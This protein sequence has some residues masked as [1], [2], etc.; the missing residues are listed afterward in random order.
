MDM[1]SDLLHSVRENFPAE[2]I[3]RAQWVLWQYELRP[4]EAKPT[5]VPYN[6]KTLQHAS[7]TDRATWGTFAE[8]CTAF[9]EN[10]F[11]GIGFVFSEDDPYFGVDLDGC[12]ANDEIDQTKLGY[13]LLLNSY[14]EESPSGTGIHIIAR[15]VMPDGKGRKSTEHKVEMYDRGRFF[16]VTGKHMDGAPTTVRE[17]QAQLDKLYKKIFGKPQTGKKQRKVAPIPQAAASDSSGSSDVEGEDNELWERMFAGQDGDKIRRLF[18]GDISD[19]G[20]DDSSADMGLCNFLA[21]RIGDDRERIERMLRQS[22]LVRDK[23]EREDY[24]DRTIDEALSSPPAGR[25]TIIKK[26]LAKKGYEFRYNLI[27]EAIEKVSG[28]NLHDG[29][30][31]VIVADLFDGGLSNKALILDVIFAL[32]WEHQYNP[33]LNY[34]NSLVWDGQ[35]HILR[36]SRFF[37][38]KHPPIEYPD[39]RTETVFTVW[40]RRWLVGAI[41]K[42]RSGAQN[43]VLVIASDQGM[44]KSGAAKWLCSPLPGFFV[45]SAINPE[46]VDHQ[47]WAASNFIW[48]VGEL[49]ATTRKADIEALKAFVTRH[50]HTFRVPY[51]KNEVHK[52]AIASFIGTVNPDNAGFLNDPT[53]SR[54]FLTVELA[55]IDWRGYVAEIDVHQVWAQACALYEEDPNSWELDETEIAMRNEIN[56]GFGIE[57]PTR[58]AVAALYETTPGVAPSND[59]PF[60][61]SLD[62]VAKVATR[63]KAASTKALQMD[64]AKA[65]KQLGVT[66]GRR[67]GI[68]GYFGLK[69]RPLVN[70]RRQG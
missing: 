25:A 31:A 64:V 63:V 44:G 20:E 13:A 60:V 28:E 9:L 19:Y 62:L 50:D 46:S 54:R 61:S 42:V 23:W 5:K 7:S 53:G 18:E 47:R 30:V 1:K 55:S 58:D 24:L 66:K 14:S 10:E 38:D 11:D 8:T 16:T 27:R 45:E 3:K 39:G 41:A 17:R 15:G 59:A 56:N 68:N 43:P 70:F 34:L 32:A 67:N 52:P 49:G 36:L 21:N 4:G 48:E 12:I 6:P 69:L 29:E 26:A 51:A 65:M 2:L 33:I 35:D 40:L 57:D 22:G 37:E